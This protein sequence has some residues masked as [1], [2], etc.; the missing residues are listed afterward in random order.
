MAA[1][2]GAFAQKK[3]LGETKQQRK[4]AAEI[5]EIKAL[6]APPKWASSSLLSELRASAIA[7]TSRTL[8]DSPVDIRKAVINQSKAVARLT[9]D[10]TGNEPTGEFWAVLL[11][12]TAA[13]DM[14]IRDSSEEVVVCLGQDADGKA[15]GAIGWWHSETRKASG[16]TFRGAEAIRCVPLDDESGEFPAQQMAHPTVT[17]VGE[18]ST[19]PAV[20]Q[21]GAQGP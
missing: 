2:A 9:H 20:Q 8:S 6:A 11:K 19:A 17:G 12:P 21:A 7:G 4:E 13:K 15:R 5:A 14:A 1:L 10:G 3:G 16:G 18:N